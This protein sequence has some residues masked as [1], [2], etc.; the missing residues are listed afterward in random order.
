VEE[1]CEY[2]YLRKSGV[3][4]PRS[5]DPLEHNVVERPMSVAVWASLCLTTMEGSKLLAHKIQ[6]H[7]DLQ[8]PYLVL[9]MKHAEGFGHDICHCDALALVEPVV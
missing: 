3:T 5:V 4:L 6:N 7:L 8:L 2:H 1:E 9:Q